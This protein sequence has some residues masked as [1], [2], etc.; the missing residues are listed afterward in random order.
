MQT[1]APPR[2]L[3]QAKKGRDIAAA[4]KDDPAYAYVSRYANTLTFRQV[5]RLDF[6]SQTLPA[7]S[8]R[9]ADLRPGHQ[10]STRSRRRRP[11]TTTCSA[12]Q[13]SSI[14]PYQSRRAVAPAKGVV[15][16]GTDDDARCDEDEYLDGY[17]IG[18]L[19]LVASA[20]TRPE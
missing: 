10:P 15:Q 20:W 17:V 8:R 9:A 12:G 6:G 16:T 11:A 4:V 18:P 3:G 2:G 1:F 19:A 13:G 14:D 7:F 5:R